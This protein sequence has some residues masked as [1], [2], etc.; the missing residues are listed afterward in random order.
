MGVEEP[1][2]VILYTNDLGYCITPTWYICVCVSACGGARGERAYTTHQ[3]SWEQQAALARETE[4]RGRE[5]EKAS[6][7]AE[8]PTSA[9]DSPGTA[10]DV[11]YMSFI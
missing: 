9:T 6:R 1:G 3:N 2:H 7:H 4:R 10:S 11:D 5:G 8:H